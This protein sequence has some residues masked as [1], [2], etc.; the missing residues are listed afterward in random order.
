MHE[1]FMVAGCLLDIAGQVQS[2]RMR[3]FEVQQ[4][5]R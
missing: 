5:I 1:G 4:S 2:K 3:S